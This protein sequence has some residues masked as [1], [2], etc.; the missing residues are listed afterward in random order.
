MKLPIK[1][2][3]IFICTISIVVILF[4]VT[5]VFGFI[6]RKANNDL[7]EYVAG[8]T[9]K[10][11]YQKGLEHKN[12]SRPVHFNTLGECQQFVNQ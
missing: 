12:I 3:D 9:G 1:I 5:Y 6:N 10:Y 4:L 2:K 8:R 11:C 7:I